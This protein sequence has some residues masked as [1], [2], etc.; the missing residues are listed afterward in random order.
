MTAINI[1]SFIWRIDEDVLRDVY[2]RGKYR[3]GK[4][5]TMPVK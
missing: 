1:S 2:V 3:E 4:S 5:L